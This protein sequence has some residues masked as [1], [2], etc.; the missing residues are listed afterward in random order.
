MRA[1]PILLA[2]ALLAACSAPV[3]VNRLTPRQQQRELAASALTT[4]RPSDAA[5]IVLRRYN[6]AATF[7]D[8]PLLALETL[9]ATALAG[10]PR[11][12][13]LFA[14]AELCYRYAD[15]SESQPYALAASLYAYAFLFPDDLATRPAPIDAR[16]RWAADIY[17]AGLSRALANEDGTALV[18][19]SNVLTLPW[20]TLE[21]SVDAAEMEWSG[22]TLTDFVPTAQYEMYGLNNRYRQPGIGVP[23]AAK[24][25]AGSKP[26]AGD[27]VAETV[28]V[29]VTA[30]LLVDDPRRQIGEAL[31]TGRLDLL[32]VDEHDSILINGVAVPLEIDRS[33]TL[34]VTLAEVGFWRQELSAFL[35]DALGTRKTATL[36]ARHPYKPGR[37]PLVMVHGTNSSPG[38]WA[39][40]VNDLENDPRIR[41]RYQFWF[42]SYDSGNPIAYSAMLLRRA[43]TAAVERLDPEHRDPCLQQMVVIGHSQGG[44]LTKMTAIDSGNAFWANISDAP[45]EDSKLSEQSRALIKEALFLEPLPFV[46]R[47]I[48]VSTPHRGSYL[49][50]YEIVGRLAARLISMPRDVATLSTDLFRDPSTRAFKM[51]RIPTSL[52]N[53]SPSQPFIKTLAAIPL[54]PDVPAH[55][56]IPVLGDGPLEDEVD[57]VVA[58]KSAHIEGVD[59]EIVIHHSGHSTQ[60][61]PRT[62]DEVRRIL[63][64]HTEKASCGHAPLRS[65]SPLQPAS[66]RPGPPKIR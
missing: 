60:G 30:V 43:L 48:F 59:S 18:L 55:S 11:A 56:I 19:K 21:V 61:D 10:G 65:T 24:P 12:D 35:G 33:A 49:A 53:M 6:L 54:S 28:R 20:G 32:L 16:V 15:E 8:Q 14:L 3:G 62:V 52:D 1:A 47:V 9:R 36:T 27:L 29:P 45:F 38:R 25:V 23:L 57:G 66:T 64:L 2:C 51:Q 58:Y 5:Q 7:E 13:D 34:A 44:L 40:M 37:I 39:D 41:A 46:S 63:L 17:A 42:F 4:D 26:V 31:I 22:R 50:S